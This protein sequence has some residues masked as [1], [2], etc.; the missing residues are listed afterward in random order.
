MKTPILKLPGIALIASAI[1][2][3]AAQVEALPPRGR[4]VEGVLTNVDTK[5][6]WAS[7][8]TDK[9]KMLSFHWSER[10]RFIKEVPPRNG[11]RASA[12]YHQPFFGEPFVTKMSVTPQPGKSP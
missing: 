5:D 3:T 9:G 7:L 1:L 4:H 11:A 2:I 12:V 8:T 6:K 10:T